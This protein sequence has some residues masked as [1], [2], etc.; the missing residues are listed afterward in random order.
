MSTPTPEQLKERLARRKKFGPR[1]VHQRG[2]ATRMKVGGRKPR[3]RRMR[4][5]PEGVRIARFASMY[6]DRSR[7]IA[8]YLRREYREAL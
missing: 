7:D 1:N 2:K 3:R 5:S 4:P 6:E 8:A